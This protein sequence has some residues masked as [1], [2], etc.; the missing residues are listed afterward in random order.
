VKC[1]QAAIRP[2]E[3]KMDT[4]SSRSPAPGA[5]ALVQAFVNTYDSEPGTE[6]L[7]SPEQLRSW[8]VGHDLA[9]GNIIATDADLDRAKLLRESLRALLETNNG[10]PGDAEAI[11]TLNLAACDARLR[12]RFNDEGRAMLEPDAQGIDGAL[13]RLLAIVYTSMAV[14]SWERLKA[15]RC[16]TCRWAFYDYSKNHSSTWCTMTTC[17][18][19]EKARAYRKRRRLTPG[20]GHGIASGV[21]A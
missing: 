9:H 5:L 17:G 15:C 14:G 19:R 12:V 4:D 11:E 2:H 8:L 18:S 20:E 21:S 3:E 16:E 13:G 7:G 6:D 1:K 10:A